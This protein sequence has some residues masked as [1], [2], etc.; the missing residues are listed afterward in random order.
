M[1]AHDRRCGHRLLPANHPYRTIHTGGYTPDGF[2]IIPAP[3]VVGAVRRNFIH[4]RS[5]TDIDEGQ[6][7]TCPAGLRRI[8]PS[9]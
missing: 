2:E 9:P 8:R 6:A 4:S 3:G 7:N 5:T 1:G